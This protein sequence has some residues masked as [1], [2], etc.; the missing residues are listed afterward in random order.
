MAKAWKSNSLR[1]LTS[2]PP[3][4]AEKA[5]ARAEY[6]SRMQKKYEWAT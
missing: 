5:A 3:D 6:R 1:G 4:L 2:H